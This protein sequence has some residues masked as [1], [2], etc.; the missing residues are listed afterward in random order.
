LIARYDPLSQWREVRVPVLLLFG[1]ADERVPV[2]VSLRNVRAALEEAQNPRV[3][4][5]VFAG[6][7]HTFRLPAPPGGNFHWPA[8]PPEYLETLLNWLV[9]TARPGR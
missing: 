1:A 9:G 4:W 3:A 5:K 7:D 8:D 6:A 2:E